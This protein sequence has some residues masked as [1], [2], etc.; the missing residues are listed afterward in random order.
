MSK[1][2]CLLFVVLLYKSSV[3][4]CSGSKKT[5]GTDDGADEETD[6]DHDH[7]TG[8]LTDDGKDKKLPTFQWTKADSA[9][10][11][12]TID[13]HDNKDPDVAILMPKVFD[14]KQDECLLSGS[15]SKEDGVDVAVNGCPGNTT[16]DV[17]FHSTRA[18]GSF[19]EILEGKTL[20]IVHDPCATDDGVLHKSSETNNTNEDQ[21]ETAQKAPQSFELKLSLHYD[22]L[23]LQHVAGGQHSKAKHKVREI[24]TLAQPMFTSWNLPSKIYLKELEVSH[25]SENLQLGDKINYISEKNDQRTHNADNY[26]YFSWDNKGGVT[27]VA[28]LGSVCKSQRSIRTGI[29][30]YL[31]WPNGDDHAQ[32]LQTSLTFAHE[33]GHSLRMDHDFCSDSRCTRQSRRTF[34][35]KDRNG[36]SCWKQ[37][38]VMD[39]DESHVTKWSTCSIEGMNGHNLGC[40]GAGD[41]GGWT[42]NPEF[43]YYCNNN[44]NYG[45]CGGSYSGWFRKNCAKTCNAC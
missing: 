38:T 27:G 37:G 7:N 13:F 3:E 31:G 23:F 42:D 20:E 30:E 15:L 11:E 41:P 32:T 22:N 40:K 17:V 35:R 6:C 28:W 19:F 39:Y 4:C 24:I 29:S 45:G 16:F 1:L 2:A 34:A 25:V 18:E 9:P 14:G 12:L 33:I 8:I 43:E 26:H 44:G 36:N 21:S 10:F 5:T